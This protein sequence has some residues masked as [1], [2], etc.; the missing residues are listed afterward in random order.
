MMRPTTK[1][2]KMVCSYCKNSSGQDDHNRTNCIMRNKNAILSILN[3]G[4]DFRE[5]NNPN[6][7]HDLDG[8]TPTHPEYMNE[9]VL[10]PEHSCANIYMYY[11]RLGHK[12]SLY[13]DAIFI[14]QCIMLKRGITQEHGSHLLHDNNTSLYFTNVNG[15]NRRIPRYYCFSISY[16]R[17]M[18][19]FTATEKLNV[20]FGLVKGLFNKYTEFQQNVRFK[21]LMLPESERA[22]AMQ[23]R[24]ER[25]AREDENRRAQ[26][27]LR[28]QRFQENLQESQRSRETVIQNYYT[29]LEEIKKKTENRTV[30]CADECPICMERFGE[31]N[32]AVLRC[33]HQLCGDCLFRHIQS[34]GGVKCPVCREVYTV[35]LPSELRG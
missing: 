14:N 34:R 8:R 3:T 24:R 6:W 19:Q 23:E 15:I 31:V 1:C 32:K 33:G 11:P 7:F 18:Q 17:E 20:P 12:N 10:H 9:S 35:A 29:K 4:V 25:H 16:N 27:R 5:F 13:N 28:E 30:V 21:Y 26:M 22:R 2:I